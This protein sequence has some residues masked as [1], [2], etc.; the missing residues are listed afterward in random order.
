[1]MDIVQIWPFTAGDD[2]PPIVDALLEHF[3]LSPMSVVGVALSGEGSR[4]Y[5]EIQAYHVRP[6]RLP[7]GIRD[8]YKVS[9]HIVQVLLEQ[10]KH[11][12]VSSSSDLRP[13]P[14]YG[15]L[16]VL[17]LEDISGLWEVKLPALG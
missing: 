8:T 3:K 15:L 1:M 2:L 14:L 5:L 17:I 6:T 13:Y 12:G 16:H 9:L 4:V 11:P 10:V 7:E